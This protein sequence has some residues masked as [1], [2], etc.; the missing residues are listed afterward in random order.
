MLQSSHHSSPTSDNTISLSYYIELL[1]VLLPLV[2]S[3]A[4]SCTFLFSLDISSLLSNCQSL[5]DSDIPDISPSTV[6]TCHVSLSKFIQISSNPS[7]LIRLQIA[8]TAT[9]GIWAIMS[10]ICPQGAIQ[11][12]CIAPSLPTFNNPNC[13]HSVMRNPCEFHLH[14]PD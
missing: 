13:I 6:H 10:G 4:A 5:C 9:V 7:N 3:S 2:S 14:S 11:C 12:A 1:R 8:I